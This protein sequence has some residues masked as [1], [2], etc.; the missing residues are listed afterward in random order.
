MSSIVQLLF[1]TSI[2]GEDSLYSISTL[3][4]G[5]GLQYEKKIIVRKLKTGQLK[6]YQAE[7]VFSM[8]VAGRGVHPLFSILNYYKTSPRL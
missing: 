4:T 8:G 2:V 1:D 6:M 7:S 5:T 3:T